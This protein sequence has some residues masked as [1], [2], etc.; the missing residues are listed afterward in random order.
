[1]REALGERIAHYRK[2]KKLSQ[3]TLASTLSVDKIT[4][5]R[6]ENGK[7]WPEYD[8]L[9][10][11]A[12]ALSIP[13]EK[14]FETI[15]KTLEAQSPT[16]ESLTRVIEDQEKR[17]AEFAK[18]AADPLYMRIHKYPDDVKAEIEKYLNMAEYDIKSK[19]ASSKVTKKVE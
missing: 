10:A 15:G 19:K 12:E 16:I 4:V 1:M 14:L 8:K 18:Y 2:L 17:L 3:G 9:M 5:W 13:A 11:I 7:S 6:W